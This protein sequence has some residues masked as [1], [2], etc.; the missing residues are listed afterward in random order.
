[1]RAVAIAAL[2]FL[3]TGAGAGPESPVARFL[4]AADKGDFA[5]MA[6]LVAARADGPTGEEQIKDL[7]GCY[8]AS[9]S[10]WEDEPDK[11]SAGFICPGGVSSSGHSTIVY[12]LTGLKGRV[13]PRF[14]VRTE[15]KTPAPPRKRSRY[16]ERPND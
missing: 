5:T 15:V 9:M 13:Y 7:K 10:W 1:M 3:A 11:A 8:L 2:A 16:E 6:S 14:H 12:N 4:K